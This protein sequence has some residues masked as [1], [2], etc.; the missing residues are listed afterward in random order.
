MPKESASH[1]RYMERYNA[2]RHREELNESG[3]LA[4]KATSRTC[5]WIAF[6]TEMYTRLNLEKYLPTVLQK[7]SERS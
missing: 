6:Y 3:I 5:N 7:L 4:L 1:K 2:A